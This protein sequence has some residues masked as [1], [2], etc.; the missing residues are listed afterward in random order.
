MG[1]E[2]LEHELVAHVEAVIAGGGFLLAML[3]DWPQSDK[4]CLKSVS[5][6]Y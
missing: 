3:Q 1:A 5:F 2:Q 6:G 4:S